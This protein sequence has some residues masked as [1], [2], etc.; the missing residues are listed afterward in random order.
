MLNKLFLEQI[1]EVVTLVAAHRH[2]TQEEL[3][4]D[5]EHAAFTATLAN[6]F[7]KRLL[8]I[9]EVLWEPAEDALVRSDSSMLVKDVV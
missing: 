5:V 4:V 6:Q 9:H 1:Q 3:L 7:V 8:K 2:D